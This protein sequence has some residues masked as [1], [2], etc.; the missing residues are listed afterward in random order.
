MNIFLDIAINLKTP[1]FE[2]AQ[3]LNYRQSTM[4]NK[5]TL[6]MG[7]SMRINR[8]R[9]FQTHFIKTSVQQIVRVATF[10]QTY[11]FNY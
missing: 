1:I 5:Y 9:S 3:I 8:C 11:N 10:H 7:M 6:S 2:I 4:T